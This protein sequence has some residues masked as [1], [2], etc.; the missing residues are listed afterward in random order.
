MIIIDR[1]H[2][3]QTQRS[4]SQDKNMKQNVIHFDMYYF[5]TQNHQPVPNSMENGKFRGSAQN[6]TVRGNC[7]P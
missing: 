2:Q 1:H 3:T 7:G 6:S 5:L 4:I